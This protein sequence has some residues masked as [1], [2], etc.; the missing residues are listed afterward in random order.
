MSDCAAPVHR[1][2]TLR[3]EVVQLSDRLSG[4]PQETMTT[5]LFFFHLKRILS[6]TRYTPNYFP[7]DGQF[8]VK[9]RFFS[10]GVVTLGVDK[11]FMG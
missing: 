2:T 3:R 10:G 11:R 8:S 6:G 9:K 1:H 7:G 5:K 4:I